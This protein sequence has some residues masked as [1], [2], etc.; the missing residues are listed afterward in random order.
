M[1]KIYSFLIM[2]FIGMALSL[3]SCSDDNGGNNNSGNGGNNNGGGQEPIEQVHYDIWVGL[4]QNAMGRFG[5][6][7]VKNVNSLESR[8]SITF[9][10]EGCDVTATFGK[11]ESSIIR[12]QYYYAVDAVNED[13]YVKYRI[14]NNQLERVAKYPLGENT[15][16]P[17]KYTHA[18]LDD[19]TLVILAANGDADEVLWTKLNANDM[20]ILAEGTLELKGDERHDVTKFTTSG[21]AAYRASDNKIIYAFKHNPGRKQTA[22][23]YFYVAFIDAETMAVETVVKEERAEEMAGTAYGELRQHKLFF[24]ENENLYL[25]CNTK[26]DGAEDNTCQYGSLLRIKKGEYAFDDYEGFRNHGSK[27]VTVDYMGN[28]KVLLYLQDPEHTGTSDDNAKYEGWGNEYNCYYAMFDLETGVLTEF[29]HEGK[30]L[31]YC[32]GTF[33]Q[34]S[35]VHGGKAYIGVNPRT[36]APCVY[37]YD[38]AEGTMVKGVEIEPGYIFTR[39]N[40]MED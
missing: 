5:T 38:I 18:W 35:F 9:R 10:G 20:S 33:S 24:D 21:L 13:R 4:E 37:V 29:E 7:L 31:P 30:K 25:A 28:G 3:G 36:E 19:N 14:M 17:G 32:S 40:Y 27:I 34:R 1:K 22:P 11:T 39:I 6:L 26:I 12:G 23:P 16:E 8:D 2:P 15:Y